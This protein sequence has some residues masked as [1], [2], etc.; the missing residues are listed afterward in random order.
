MLTYL[1]WLGDGCDV[2]WQLDFGMELN[3]TMSAPV[4]GTPEQSCFNQCL[5]DSTCDAMNYNSVAMTCTYVR[6][7]NIQTNVNPAV[8]SYQFQRQPNCSK[9]F[10][11]HTYASYC[12]QKISFTTLCIT[13]CTFDVV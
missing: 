2:A 1:S 10:Y 8:N 4:S 9:F 13:F 11:K 6:G 3:G 5:L 12:H 7:S